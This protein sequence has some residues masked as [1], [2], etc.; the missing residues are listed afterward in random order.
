DRLAKRWPKVEPYLF[1]VVPEAIMP[2]ALDSISISRDK[3]ELYL[4]LLRP[5]NRPENG[6]KEYEGFEYA[7]VLRKISAP[8]GLTLPKSD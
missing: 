4:M 5:E 2:T 6:E 8:S 1:D 3:K 7:T